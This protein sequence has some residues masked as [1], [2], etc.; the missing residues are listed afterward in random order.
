M[1][2]QMIDLTGHGATVR[3]KPIAAVDVRLAHDLAICGVHGTADLAAALTETMTDA[4][5]AADE[6]YPAG[7]LFYAFA[8]FIDPGGAG[9]A[10]I[11]AERIGDN[12]YALY[13]PTI[14]G[15]D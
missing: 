12:G 13:Y 8:H 1:K 14:V 10:H 2:M 5:D 15:E 3:G 7:E 9:K 11:H 6:G 4:L